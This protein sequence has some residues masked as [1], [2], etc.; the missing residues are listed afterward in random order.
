MSVFPTKSHP[1][2]PVA[3][4]QEVRVY[5]CLGQGIPSAHQLPVSCPLVPEVTPAVIFSV[6]LR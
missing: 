6:A 5:W 4:K 3:P 1:R 2:G